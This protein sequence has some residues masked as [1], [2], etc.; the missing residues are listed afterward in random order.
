[1][2]LTAKYLH[3]N[4]YCRFPSALADCPEDFMNPPSQFQ[5]KALKKASRIKAPWIS[6]R[7]LLP[8]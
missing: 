1:M 6:R 5:V 3:S 4:L 7:F 8:H 2:H